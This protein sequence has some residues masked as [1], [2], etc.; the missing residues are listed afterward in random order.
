M[1]DCKLYGPE[2]KLISEVEPRGEMPILQE[3]D[4]RIHFNCDDSEGVNARA[5]VTIISRGEPLR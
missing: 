5:N 4:N 1:S 2:G 3:G